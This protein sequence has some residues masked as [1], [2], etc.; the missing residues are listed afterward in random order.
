MYSYHIG[1]QC[2]PSLERRLRAKITPF[3]PYCGRK[4]PLL[5]HIFSIGWAD[6]RNRRW[7]LGCWYN[8]Q[9]PKNETVGLK[10]SQII[11][12][13]IIKTI[14]NPNYDIINFYLKCYIPTKNNLMHQTHTMHQRYTHTY[15]CFLYKCPL[16]YLGC[17][18]NTY[19]K[20]TIYPY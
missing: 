19:R 18:R 2:N 8:L 15:A 10:S 20:L 11:V 7:L 3:N 14:S 1:L 17:R 5:T 12:I 13:H 9:T 6:G 4:L 16:L